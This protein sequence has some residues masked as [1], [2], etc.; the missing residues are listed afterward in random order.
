ME[1]RKAFAEK[2]SISKLDYATVDNPF[3]GRVIW[4]CNKKYTVKGEK[5]CE[6]KHID[7][8]VLYQAFIN[9]FN[10]IIEN[11]NYFMEKWKEHLK[12]NN[13]L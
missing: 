11:K 8:R 10:A 13:L 12:S 9:T 7:D 3:D 6:N 5:S 4:R 1:R 2:Y